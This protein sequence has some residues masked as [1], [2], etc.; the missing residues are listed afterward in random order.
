[1]LPFRNILIHQP[2]LTRRERAEQVCRRD[3]LAKDGD[4]APAV[5]DARLDQ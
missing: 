4:E 2:P 1:M 3:A 5:L